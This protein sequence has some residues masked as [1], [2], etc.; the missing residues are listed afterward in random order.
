MRSERSR[1]IDLTSR[2]Y[3]TLQQGVG[4]S[5]VAGD[6]SW[7]LLAIPAEPTP[8]FRHRY[9][10]LLASIVIPRQHEIT[11]YGI[12][13]FLRIG[14]VADV[15]KRVGEQTFT[16]KSR[17]DVPVVDPFFQFPDGNVSW[18]LTFIPNQDSP[19]QLNSTVSAPQPR[20]VSNA[21]YPFESSLQALDLG[22]P[23]V[24]PPGNIPGEPLGALGTF[25][26][27][28]FTATNPQPTLAYHQ[29]GPGIL[30]FWATVQQTDPAT[31]VNPVFPDDFD[32]SCLLPDARFYANAP[33][34]ARYTQI[35]GRILCDIN[36]MSLKPGLGGP[37]C[38]EESEPA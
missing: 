13:Q 6:A 26:E 25:N 34:L 29:Q 4:T 7:P 33:A 9:R 1:I 8:D 10:F 27:L 30:A 11:V 20:G 24:P 2:A 22:P 15:E 18:H 14:Y 23:Y 19:G 38:A 36:A 31:R 37:P 17:V 28:R 35:G 3:Q 21:Q 12:S 5:P 16:V 32:L